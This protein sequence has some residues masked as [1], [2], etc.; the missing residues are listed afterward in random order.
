VEE[1]MKRLCRKIIGAAA[2]TLAIIP[3]WGNEA[4]EVFLKTAYPQW[5]I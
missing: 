5:T 4:A 3:A 1:I 2:L